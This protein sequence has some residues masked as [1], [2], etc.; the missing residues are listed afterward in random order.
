M[1]DIYLATRDRQDLILSYVQDILNVVSGND[2]LAK[3]RIAANYFRTRASRYAS[4]EF[5]CSW[6]SWET[7]HLSEGTRTKNAV[8]MVAYPSTDETAARNDFDNYFYGMIVNTQINNT[9]LV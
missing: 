7:S 1:S 8:N 6:P 3:S 2:D 4:L 5:G 9:I